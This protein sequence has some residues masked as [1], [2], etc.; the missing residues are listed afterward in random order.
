MI[1]ATEDRAGDARALFMPGPPASLPFDLRCL[2]DDA[3]VLAL[4]DRRPAP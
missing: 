3:S 4:P 1:V 2:D